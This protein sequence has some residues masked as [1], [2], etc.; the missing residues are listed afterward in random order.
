ML[1]SFKTFDRIGRFD[2]GNIFFFRKHET[3]FES[4]DFNF[5][6]EKLFCY[7]IS[8]KDAKQVLSSKAKDNFPE[9]TPE[10]YY[11]WSVKRVGRFAWINR[12]I[13]YAHTHNNGWLPKAIFLLLCLPFTPHQS[14]S[15]GIIQKSFSLRWPPCKRKPISK[16][17]FVHSAN[18]WVQWTLKMHEA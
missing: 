11:H 13:L 6:P 8:H 1:F 16:W 3:V 7:Y 15:A 17:N 10:S 9:L 4:I 5:K 18:S 14:E 2:F 12:M